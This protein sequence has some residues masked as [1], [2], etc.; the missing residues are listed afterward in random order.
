MFLS[1]KNRIQYSAEAV[2]V[3]PSPIGISDLE[4]AGLVSDDEEA[5]E[6]IAE[7][8]RRRLPFGVLAANGRFR[9]GSIYR[10][11]L[12]AAFFA[13]VFAFMFAPVPA[14]AKEAYSAELMLRSS[15]KV[16]LMPG[17]TTSYTVAFKNT[18][19]ETWTAYG[20]HFVSIYTYEPKYRESKFVDPVWLNSIQPAH[21]MEQVVSPGTIGRV[22]FNLTAPQKPGKYTEIFHLAAEDLLWIPGGWFSVEIE[23]SDPG[24]NQLAPALSVSVQTSAPVVVTPET[25]RFQAEVVSVSTPRVEMSAGGSATYTI[26][27]RNTGRETW[28]GDGRG[29][30]SIYTHGPK[31]R[32][33]I[34]EDPSWYGDV[35]PVRIRESSVAPGE[36]G[37]ISFTLSAPLQTGNY[38]EVFYLASEDTAWIPGGLFTVGIKVTEGLGVVSAGTIPITSE[39]ADGF[40]ALKLLVSARDLELETG[41]TNTF[42]VGFKNAGDRTWAYSGSEPIT[43]SAEPGNSYFFRHGS[44]PA[45][46]VVAR[47]ASNEVKPGELAF[48]DFTLAAPAVKGNY[49]TRF[50]LTAG[51]SPVEGGVLEIPIEVREGTAPS[52]LSS[53]DNPPPPSGPRGPNIRVGLFNTRSAV[54]V[55]AAGTYKLIEGRGHTPVRQLSGVTTVN[56]D[57]TN[58]TYTVTNGSYRQVFDVH[59][60]LRPDDMANT[61][62]EISS[63][64]NRP[65]WDPSINF[66][67]FR[68]DL[69]IHYSAAKDRLWVIEELP[70]EDYLRGLAETSNG[71]PME[72]QKALVTAARTFAVFVQSIGGKHMSEYFDVATGAG[73]QVYKGYVSETIRPNVVIA[74]EQTRGQVVTLDGD[75][76]VTPYFS[77]SDGRTRSWT[78]VW[79]STPHSW[80]VSVPAPYDAGKTLWG[81][82]VGMSASDAI[83][84]A[85][86]GASWQD[87]LKYYYTGIDI[88]QRY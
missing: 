40:R 56:F 46:N 79:S 65:T 55:V 7:L 16:T 39:S 81:H 86:D 30:A 47:L 28:T 61:I 76:V 8:F 6:G 51:S 41:A 67:R 70:M 84:R 72:Y 73:D 59:V 57:F 27:F 13:L 88:T 45:Q 44:W 54:T 63:Y 32:T 50:V 52:R 48:F 10:V 19:Y 29:F 17:E 25:P 35:Q 83:G 49:T 58:R 11:R 20:P 26:A 36:T 3:E 34:F 80:L 38:S 71:S 42:R 85:K 18:G 15:D 14:D 62:F 82:G 5:K 74:V 66:N 68:G 4:T 23:V 87:I 75:V 69:S 1:G 12:L 9:A 64:T 31:Y 2:L 24:A 33:S 21:T 77:R 53:Y 78:E 22:M 60:H 37:T 43:L